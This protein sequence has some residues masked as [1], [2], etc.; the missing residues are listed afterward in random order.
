M[1]RI[2]RTLCI[3]LVAVAALGIA[4]PASAGQTGIAAATQQDTASPTPAE[5]LSKVLDQIAAKILTAD[6]EYEIEQ[7]IESSMANAMNKLDLS[8]DDITTYRLTQ[9][10]K[11]KLSKSLSGVFGNMALAVGGPQASEQLA[12]LTSMIDQQVAQATTLNGLFSAL[13]MDLT[14]AVTGRSSF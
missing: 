3:A 12:L 2:K 11:K 10:D 14:S 13:G 6:S 4:S 5:K 1:K 7:I 9:S 8:Y